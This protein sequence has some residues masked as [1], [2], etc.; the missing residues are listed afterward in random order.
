MLKTRAE[1]IPHLHAHKSNDLSQN[2]KCMCVHG[3]SFDDQ[4][5]LEAQAYLDGAVATQP[6]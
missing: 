1:I 2:D 4:G 5:M 3:M 6:Q